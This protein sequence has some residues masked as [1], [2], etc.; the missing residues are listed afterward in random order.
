MDQAEIRLASRQT[1]MIV[2]VNLVFY[3]EVEGGWSANRK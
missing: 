2:V 3:R 1:I